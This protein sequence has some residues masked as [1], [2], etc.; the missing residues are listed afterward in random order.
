M[1][2]LI[3][4]YLVAICQMDENVAYFKTGFDSL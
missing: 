3:I 1:H 4:D 2:A